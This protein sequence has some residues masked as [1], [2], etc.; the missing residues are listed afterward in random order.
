[1]IS[2]ISSSSAYSGM[3]RP[4]PAKMVDKMFSTLDT[5]GKGYIDKADLQTALD[6]T[7]SNGKSGNTPSVDEVFKKLDSN[8]DGK[9]TKQEMTDGVKNLPTNS[10]AS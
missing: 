2:N 1:M 3:Q 6:Q 7:S 8:G 9:I 5:T 10:T 4:D